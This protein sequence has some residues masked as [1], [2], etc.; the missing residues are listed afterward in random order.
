MKE[1]ESGFFHSSVPFLY[2]GH[3]T[4]TK[5]RMRQR[6]K[7]ILTLLH[8]LFFL[9]IPACSIQ[10]IA[11][12][13]VADMLTAPGGS[14]VYTSDNDPELVGDALPFTIKLYESLMVSMPDHS[15][16]RLRTGSLYIMYANAFIQTPATMLSDDE[17]KKQEFMYKRAMNLYLRGRDILLEELENK[18]PGFRESLDKREYGEA[19]STTTKEDLDFLYWAAAGWLGAYAINPL[20]MDL[21]LTIPGASALM[22]RVLKLDENYGRGAIHEFY[23]LYYGSLPEY[24]GGDVRKAREHFEKAVAASEGKSTSAYLSLA[25]TVCIKEQNLAEFRILLEKVLEIDIDADPQNRLLNIL[26][27]RKAAWYLEHVDD[28]FIETSA[29]TEISGRRERNL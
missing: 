1:L 23:V 18:H 27:Q 15:G 24:M 7:G 20:D 10:K 17:Y 2:N 21:G 26:N 8:T 9:L 25:S 22:E 3:N 11:M 13:K 28:F 14:S 19:I 6:K 5:I 12:T 4:K 16:L 29:P